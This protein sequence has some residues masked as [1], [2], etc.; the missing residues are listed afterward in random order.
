MSSR[1]LQ[2]VTALMGRGVIPTGTPIVGADDLGLTRGH[3]CFDATRVWF[4]SGTPVVED[5][6]A[7]LT[8]LQASASALGITGPSDAAWHDL[9]KQVCAAYEGDAEA[10]L[11]LVLTGG[12]ESL[13]A[14]PV[15][16]ATLTELSEESLR[17]RD[18]VTVAV[19]SR[20]VASD[21]FAD[22]P[23]LLGGVKTIAYAINL[24]AKEEAH[25]RGADDALFVS[26][27]GFALEGP[28]SAVVIR[29]GTRLL[30]TPTGQTGV[31]ASIT[32]D[33][34]AREAATCG[35]TLEHELFRP[36][37][38][39]TADGAW[40]VSS[41][42]GVAPIRRLIP[43]SRPPALDELTELTSDSHIEAEP[44]NAG[45]PE[46]ADMTADLT[47]DLPA[48]PEGDCTLRTLAG[49]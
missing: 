32:I 3:G 5:L 33:R 43:T 47:I 4:D 48:D 16:Y 31:L 28:T 45:A 25:R 26:T 22:A 29:R 13:T 20:G 23:W 24:E 49:F 30:T 17:Q 38:L 8:R 35:Y 14:E 41:V 12:G 19:L 42:R 27:D 11:K 2:Q 18:G 39:L 10:G 15:A 9:V 40:L 37:D 6:D 46:A 1:S 34:I 36:H 21:A 44:Q 7:H